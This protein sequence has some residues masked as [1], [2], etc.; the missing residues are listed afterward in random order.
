MDKKGSVTNTF[1]YCTIKQPNLRANSWL[2]EDVKTM[3]EKLHSSSSIT[4]KVCLNEENSWEVQ[5]FSP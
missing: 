2:E 5:D 4:N 1:L 3:K